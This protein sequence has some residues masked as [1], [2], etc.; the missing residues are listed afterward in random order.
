MGLRWCFQT[1]PHL[2]SH[3]GKRGSWRPAISVGVLLALVCWARFYLLLPPPRQKLATCPFWAVCTFG[4]KTLIGT[5]EKKGPENN[6]NIGRCKIASPWTRRMKQNHLTW[7]TSWG[8]FILRTCPLQG[9]ALQSIST[10][11]SGSNS[12]SYIINS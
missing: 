6:R 3:A 1:C 5:E 11:C 7:N 4:M 9:E 10:A 8:Q 12:A 2:C